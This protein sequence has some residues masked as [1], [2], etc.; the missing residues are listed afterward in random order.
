MLI[1]KS[2]IFQKIILILLRK[3][4]YSICLIKYKTLA[5]FTLMETLKIL[6]K[7]KKFNLNLKLQLLSSLRYMTVKANAVYFILDYKME[8]LKLKIPVFRQSLLHLCN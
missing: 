7:F 5:H 1:I 4:K 8:H 3:I 2:R 6:F